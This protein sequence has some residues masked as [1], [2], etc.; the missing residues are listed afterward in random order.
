[1]AAPPTEEDLLLLRVTDALSW[2]S[3]GL[4]VLIGIGYALDKRSRKY[5]SSIFLFSFIAVCIASFGVPFGLIAGHPAL[6]RVPSPLCTIQAIFAH[7]G[8]LSWT[9]WVM[10]LTISLYRLIL[11]KPT[12]LNPY[13]QQVQYLMI[14]FVVPIAPVLVNL[15][16]GKYGPSG[17]WCYISASDH[18]LW[19][20]C[21]HIIW[22]V[23]MCVVTAVLLAITLHHLR[24]SRN[25]DD[26]A[27]KVRIRGLNL[28]LII[29]LALYLVT[30][31]LAQ[32]IRIRGIALANLGIPDP[33][34]FGA[35]IGLSISA[36]LSGWV[37]LFVFGTD[38]TPYR[39]LVCKGCRR[40]HN[41]NSDKSGLPLQALSFGA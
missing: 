31:L 15:I 11:Q 29:F 6:D 33:Q 27:M 41:N 4:N 17:L 36:S 23:S 13:R 39:F 24:T 8:Y 9:I 30:I 12:S 5:P 19:L 18:G 3:F 2:T 20:L 14:G 34:T 10:I 38:W 7:Y 25:S 22:V 16:A 37:N 21:T 28:R 1:M 40:R 35:R 26:T 32:I